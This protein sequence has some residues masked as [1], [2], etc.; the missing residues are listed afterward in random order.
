M[1]YRI[2]SADDHIDLQWLPKDLWQKRVPSAWRDRAPKVVETADGPYWVCGGD[3]W[4]P[5][6]GRM[7][8]AGAMGGRR[9]ALERGGVL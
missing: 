2:I 4:D 5:W 9:L 6:G 3:R 1:E 8:A 7:G